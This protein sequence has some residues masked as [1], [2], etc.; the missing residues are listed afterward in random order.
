MHKRNDVLVAIAEF[1]GVA[2]SAKRA[3]DA[4]DGL[5]WDRSVRPKSAELA[6]LSLRRGAW[7][8]AAMDGAE[9]PWES[10]S[11]GTVE[12]SPMG[13]TVERSLALSAE[14]HTLVDVYE[15][16]P[17][18]AWARMHTIVAAGLVT[19]DAVGRPRSNEMAADPLRLGPVP[20]AS[21]AADRLTVLAT[22]I[23]TPTQAP[24]IVQA[25]IVHGEL[26][27]VRPFATGSGLVSRAAIRLALAARGVDPDLL[28]VPESGL[29]TLGRAKYVTALRGF[30]SGTPDGMTAWVTWFCEAIRIGAEQA[31]RMAAEL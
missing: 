13:Q 5:L 4:V 11:S 16:A 31:H 24:G 1:D 10:V 8:N 21:E 18:Q 3:R 20:L 28:T 29:L 6:A 2:E 25:A 17:L 23:T 9:V 26:A 19:A 15:R 30:A 14:L 27:V 22:I 12:E 7:A